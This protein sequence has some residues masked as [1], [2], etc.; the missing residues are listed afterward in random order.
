M[1]FLLFFFGTGLLCLP[2]SD[3][4][5][6][7]DNSSSNSCMAPVLLSLNLPCFARRLKIFFCN[8]FSLIIINIYFFLWQTP[9]GKWAGVGF[10]PVD[11]LA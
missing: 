10:C 1:I 6:S 9:L 7:P 3:F 4:D 8:F 5:K 11:S 2:A